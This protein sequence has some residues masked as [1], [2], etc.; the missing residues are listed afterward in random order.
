MTN[1]LSSLTDKLFLTDGLASDCYFTLTVRSR[2]ADNLM[3]RLSQVGT[4]A[5]T[6]LFWHSGFDDQVVRYG[7]N[8]HA[9]QSLRQRSRLHIEQLTDDRV[10]ISLAFPHFLSDAQ[11]GLWLLSEL[12]EAKFDDTGMELTP[13]TDSLLERPFY[14]TIQ[15]P[16]LSPLERFSAQSI[17]H[18][19]GPQSE[20][21]GLV[22]S[23]RDASSNAKSVGNQF[24]VFTLHPK[25]C[26]KVCHLPKAAWKRLVVQW[27]EKLQSS[28]TDNEVAVENLADSACGEL[29][30]THLGAIDSL[31]DVGIN[32][33][34]NCTLEMIPTHPP[35]FQKVLVSYSLGHT[36]YLVSSCPSLHSKLKAE[37]TRST[38]GAPASC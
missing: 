25:L 15:I 27:K 28:S 24:R 29:L 37:L 33:L 23:M 10:Q 5:V 26:T 13:L 36:H 14:Q 35:G 1:N 11:H 30:L 7:L 34:E 9:T 22:V 8:E 31:V 12:I 19:I 2:Q 6:F 18:L 21:I 17:L 20:S 16:L 32:T 38:L 3:K 4:A